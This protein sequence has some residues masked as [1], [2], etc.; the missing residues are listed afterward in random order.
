MFNLFGKSKS[1]ELGEGVS[2]TNLSE[3]K[4][5]YSIQLDSKGKILFVSF[6]LKEKSI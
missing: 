5:K 3:S 6:G 4:A 1:N 2:S